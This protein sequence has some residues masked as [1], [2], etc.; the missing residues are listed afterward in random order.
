MISENKKMG[1]VWKQVFCSVL[2]TLYTPK[3]S[4]KKR[5]SLTDKL[6]YCFCT[7]L[8]LQLAYDTTE[9]ILKFWTE[10]SHWRL[11]KQVNE[12]W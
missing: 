2:L 3:S 7:F 9:D 1:K 11:K 12:D 10:Q 5:N 6:S 8:K 4:F